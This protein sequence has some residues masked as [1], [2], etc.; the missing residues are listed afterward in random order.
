[1][2]LQESNPNLSNSLVLPLPPRGMLAGASL[3]LDID[4]TLF[5]LIDDPAA[6]RADAALH[7]LLAALSI[8]LRGR[9]ALISGRSIDQIDMIFGDAA[10]NWAVAGSHGA[11]DRWRGIWSRPE[12]PDALVAAAD[13]M[14]AFAGD[15]PG[16]LVEEK[17]FGVALHYRL[18][19]AA[20]RAAHTIARGLADA[21]GLHLQCGDHVVELRV[22]GADKGGALQR[23]M[24]RAP[25]RDARPVFIGDDLTDESAFAAARALGGCGVL[26][27]A[28]RESAATYRLTSP[29][30][31][32]AW[33][34]EE[35][36]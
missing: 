9:L 20:A 4:G 17:S 25:M 26:I 18:A 11:E 28:P 7:T 22:G 15:T 3:F 21:L 13:A 29:A 32:R 1:M 24:E 5:D 36:A 14:R 2:H 8:K 12:R 30:A 27:G 16:A 34:R 35:L 33:L 23:M 6:V 10:Q 31:L 19:P